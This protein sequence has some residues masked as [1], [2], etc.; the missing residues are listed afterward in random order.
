M[1]Q[2]QPK[3]SQTVSK[4]VVAVNTTRKTT[5]PSVSSKQGT[6]LISHHEVASETIANSASYSVFGTYAM[7]PAISTYSH[8]SPLG[9]WLPGIAKEYDNFEFV[10]L[11]AHYVPVCTTLT[12]GLIILSYDPNPNA[13]APSSFTDAS[14][15]MCSVSG[16]VRQRLVLDMTK[17]VAGRK[18]LTRSRTVSEYALYDAGRLFACTFAG[19]NTAN[20]GY[21]E[22]EYTVRFTNPQSEGGS[23]VTE[24]T[25]MAYPTYLAVGAT[26]ANGTSVWFGT[27]G[28]GATS[29][30]CTDFTNTI[31]NGTTKY[32]DTSLVSFVAPGTRTTLLSYTSPNNVVHTLSTGN[33]VY[34]IRLARQGLWRIRATLPGDW[35]NYCMFGAEILKW[36]PNDSA[37]IAAPTLATKAVLNN[38]GD[39]VTIPTGYGAIRGFKTVEVGG[40]DNDDLVLEYDDVVY[41]SN[42]LEQYALSIGMRNET[43]VSENTNGSYVYNSNQGNPRFELTYLGSVA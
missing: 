26:A 42:I 29:K 11:K 37:R 38:T 25:A 7:Q 36:G 4:T 31:C 32:G 1:P 12:P 6:T 15:A 18:L 30:T 9:K 19:D 34:V 3:K 40:T 24:Y 33:P 13:S 41:V 21:L 10:S 27:Q 8:G 16:P 23:A 35:Q 5:A 39:L 43:A 2:R 28:S 22:F 17:Y 20:V 14:N